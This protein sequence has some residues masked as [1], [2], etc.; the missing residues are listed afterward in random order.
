VRLIQSLTQDKR[1]NLAGVEM[2]MTLTRQLEEAR[3]RLAHLEADLRAAHERMR[4]EVER[5]RRSS[6]ADLVPLRNT[7]TL[8]QRER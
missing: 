1:V 2:V 5:V 3:R 7:I 8:Y 4:D 6:R